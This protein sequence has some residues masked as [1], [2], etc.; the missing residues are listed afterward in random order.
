M[1]ASVHYYLLTSL[2]DMN[3]MH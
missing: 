1:A 2:G 3:A